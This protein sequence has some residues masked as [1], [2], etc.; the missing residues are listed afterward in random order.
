M[1]YVENIVA[2]SAFFWQSEKIIFIIKTDAYDTN[3]LGVD[4][5]TISWLLPYYFLI[6]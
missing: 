4:Y 2:G 3:L 1:L 5:Y 6:R